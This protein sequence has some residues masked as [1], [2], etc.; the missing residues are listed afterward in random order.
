MFSLV[1]CNSTQGYGVFLGG[2][3]QHSR[4]AAYFLGGRLEP[5]RIHISLAVYYNPQGNAK[6]HGG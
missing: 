5:P 3:Q 2:L 1:V 4:K 6:L